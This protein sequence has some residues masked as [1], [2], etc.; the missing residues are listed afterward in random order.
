MSRSGA[1]RG[2]FASVDQNIS[3]LRVNSKLKEGF[4]FWPEFRSEQTLFYAEQTD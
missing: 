2:L 1:Q 4:V 3:K